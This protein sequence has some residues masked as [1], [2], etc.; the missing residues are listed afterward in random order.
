M[1]R[2]TEE[3]KEHLRERTIDALLAIRREYLSSGQ[4]NPLKHWDQLQDRMRAAART[5]SSAEE[6]T[7][8]V[9]RGLQLSAP[10]KSS[11]GS[12]GALVAAVRKHGASPWLEIVEREHGYLIASARLQ[13]DKKREA[14]EQL[15]AEIDA[16]ETNRTTT[17][18]TT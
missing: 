10:S 17:K 3:A 12:L 16:L 18:E 5:T 2:L 1:A 7:T 14:R 15:E 11:S 8:A 13:A 6:W 4:A 9:M